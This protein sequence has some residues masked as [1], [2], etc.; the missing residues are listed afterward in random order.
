M[1]RLFASIT[2]LTLILAACSHSGSDENEKMM[3]VRRR[4]KREK[5]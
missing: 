2:V 4:N 3:I 5:V 1:K